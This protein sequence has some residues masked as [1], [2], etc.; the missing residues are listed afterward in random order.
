[1]L[2][3][4]IEYD[5]QPGSKLLEHYIKEEKGEK[6][7]FIRGTWTVADEP[8]RNKRVYPLK[9]LKREMEKLNEKAHEGVW[10]GSCD[11]PPTPDYNLSDAAIQILN[12]NQDKKNEKRFLGEAMVIK[13]SEKG[14]T[15]FAL[16]KLGL[17]PGISS[18][19][20]GEVDEK[21]GLSYVGES[22]N[23]ITFDAVSDPSCQ[24]AYQ[25]VFE[26][27]VEYFIDVKTGYIK[28]ATESMRLNEKL[29]GATKSELKK[30][31]NEVYTTFMDQ[32]FT[33][34]ALFEARKN[35]K[36]KKG[37]MLS[38]KTESAGMKIGDL[39]EIVREPASAFVPYLIKK[40]GNKIE[41]TISRK[42]LTETFEIFEYNPKAEKK[43]KVI[44]EKTEVLLEVKKLLTEAKVEYSSIEYL[45]E[46]K[47]AVKTG[48]KET[49]A[50]KKCV[51][52]MKE[53]LKKATSKAKAAD[54]EVKKAEKGLAKAKRT[55]KEAKLNG[56]Y[57]A[58]IKINEIFISGPF[59]YSRTKE[60]VKKEMDKYKKELDDCR[61]EKE[62][63]RLQAAIKTGENLLKT[64]KESKINEMVT[65]VGA[66]PY[67]AS[68]EEVIEIMDKY[69]KELD[70][71]KDEKEC[72]KIRN[73]IQAGEDKL[74]FFDSDEY[75]KHS[76]EIEKNRSSRGDLKKKVITKK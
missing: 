8:N 2:K 47:V 11:H 15:L 60:Q 17:K 22:L 41:H 16:C 3:L 27:G 4:L 21:D 24:E 71:C 49:F 33:P 52:K 58:V 29:K 65:I 64:I 50:Q 14:Q 75:K 26:E 56:E 69:K 39:Y 13:D 57:V 37:A 35:D 32:A 44:S 76:E 63:K 18:R 36:F 72:K 46:K 12:I 45:G 66:Y 70:D 40:W 19:A 25:K 31:I 30:V 73:M 43:A 74:R 54:K 1:M 62:C 48:K 53:T 28:E 20:V 7:V 67:D 38:V 42:D 5:A 61:D 9:Y 68:K 51:A 59:H 34:R 6:N 10:A 55:I 23:M